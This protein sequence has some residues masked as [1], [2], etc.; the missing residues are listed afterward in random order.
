MKDFD[1]KL[2]NKIAEVCN[3][4]TG[5]NYKIDNKFEIEY[6]ETIYPR[7]EVQYY[8]MQRQKALDGTIGAATLLRTTT[9]LDAKSPAVASDEAAIKYIQ[10]NQKLMNNILNQNTENPEVI[11]NV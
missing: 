6:I 3:A 9:D 2:V 11:Q 8:Q 1:R 7:D 5:T 10:D 4:Q